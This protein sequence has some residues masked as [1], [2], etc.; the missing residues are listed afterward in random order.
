M[1]RAAWNAFEA[2]AKIPGYP[3]TR[4]PGVKSRDR[5]KKGSC[6]SEEVDSSV[7]RALF[8]PFR[9]E[10]FARRQGIR[11]FLL[12]RS[13]YAFYTTPRGRKRCERVI[14]R[15]NHMC[16]GLEG[17]RMETRS[18]LRRTLRCDSPCPRC[19]DRSVCVRD[20]MRNGNRGKGFVHG[21]TTATRNRR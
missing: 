6:Y 9:A 20:T 7:C 13:T 14:T 21:P 1:T 8:Q 2:E 15:C 17:L 11:Y 3:F 4:R 16:T 18:K 19:S 10:Q 12:L 5:G